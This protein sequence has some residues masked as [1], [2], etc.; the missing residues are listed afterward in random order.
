MNTASSKEFSSG[1][2]K[3]IYGE[4]LSILG[5]GG[6]EIK[7]ILDQTEEDPEYEDSPAF[8]L[9]DILIE[10]ELCAD[11]DW[12]FGADDVEYNL[13]L[14][15][16]RLK[17]AP[18]RE[19]PPYEEGQPLG[20]EALE[21]IMSECEHAAIAIFDGDTIYVFLTDKEKAPMLKAQ[22]DKLEEFWVLRDAFIV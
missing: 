9:L 6:E 7:E 22:M 14:L 13:N 4:I 16:K 15:A 12:K 11:L 17:M 3:E 10:G 20:Y 18:I 19:Y 1:K 21:M 8:A 5:L 2:V